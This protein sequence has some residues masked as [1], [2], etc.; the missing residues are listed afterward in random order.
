MER[1][2]SERAKTAR[3]TKE[4]GTVGFSPTQHQR[5]AELGYAESGLEALF[6][7]AGDRDARFESLSQDLTQET[8]A[9]LESLRVERHR[10]EVRLVES[11]LVDALV[12]AGFVEVVTPVIIAKASLAKMGLTETHPLW[13]QVYWVDG[14][15]CLRP[16]L[17]P[18]LYVMLSHLQR[19]W[20]SPVRI[21]EVG[22]C[23]RKES[24]GA[25]HLSEFTMLNLVELTS[26]PGDAE[27]QRELAELVMGRLGLDFHLAATDSEV[28]GA[29]VDVEVGGIEVASGVVGPHPLDAEWGIQGAWTGLGFGLERLAMLRTGA[30]RVHAVGR[31]LAYLDGARLNVQRMRPAAPKRSEADSGRTA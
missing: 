1:E 11:E 31:S 6:S 16:M 29:T 20:P 5:L 8:L 23:F 18:N 17:A 12:S 30:T 3:T 14:D 24:K 19:L 2:T 9:R 13:R 25:N 22:P 21:F 4:A 7:S 27:R 10:P 26:E 15:R 28:Y